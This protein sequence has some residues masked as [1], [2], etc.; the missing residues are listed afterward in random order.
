MAKT[1]K[2][3]YF[4]AVKEIIRQNLTYDFRK[5]MPEIE[6]KLKEFDNTQKILKRKPKRSVGYE[7]MDIYC[8]MMAS[9]NRF[10]EDCFSVYDMYQKANSF[11]Q[12]VRLNSSCYA[13]SANN[14]LMDY[15]D[16]S[17]L[18]GQR[19]KDSRFKMKNEYYKFYPEQ[20]EKNDLINK[21][22]H[23][24]NLDPKK[25]DKD[26]QTLID[27]KTEKLRKLTNDFRLS[28]IV[29]LEFVEKIIR[30]MVM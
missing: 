23:L 13:W 28:E 30:E 9:D 6:K 18:L 19:G 26:I 4:D 11:L 24:V 7:I 22:C 17:L 12:E 14:N 3:Q 1:K 15:M 8:E 5:C 29:R 27:I 21:I 2:E 25:Q 16:D 10:M 20:K